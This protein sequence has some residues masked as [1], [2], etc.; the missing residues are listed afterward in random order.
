MKVLSVPVLALFTCCNAFAAD[1]VGVWQGKRVVDI[2]ARVKLVRD[3]IKNLK[4]EHRGQAEGYIST[5]ESQK[6]GLEG[7][8]GV[9]LEFKKG[10]VVL[11]SQG[12]KVVQGKWILKGD[13]LKIAGFE[14]VRGMELVKEGKLSKKGV[15]TFDMT[16]R[17]P[18][19]S[20]SMFQT[21]V[22]KKV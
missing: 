5:L 18:G 4:P 1:L 14:K 20:I 2:S 19:R 13:T 3:N 21:L 17:V 6:R 16:Y 10:G 7:G 22:C 12:Q 8:P 11:T 9:T 15:L